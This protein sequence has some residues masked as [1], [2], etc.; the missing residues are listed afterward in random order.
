MALKIAICKSQKRQ[1][2]CGSLYD[3]GARFYDPVIG[4]WN[5]VDPK[6]DMFSHMSPYNYGITNPVLMIDPDGMAPTYNWDTGK[7]EDEGKEVSWDQV[8]KEYG[9]NQTDQE[10]KNKDQERKR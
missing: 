4:R 1:K 9:I 5:V 6:A 10:P 2:K 7:Y 3:Y 8:Q